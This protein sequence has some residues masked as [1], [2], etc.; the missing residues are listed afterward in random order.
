[1]PSYLRFYTN[2]L[3]ITTAI[4]IS[5]SYEV[6]EY[7]Q[8]L[9]IPPMLFSAAIFVIATY[10]ADVIFWTALKFKPV[11]KVVLGRMWVE[12]WWLILTYDQKDEALLKGLVQMQ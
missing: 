6:K 9:G 1:M 8:V 7:Y 11:R 5:T 12:G 2:F 4:C 10:I 3:V